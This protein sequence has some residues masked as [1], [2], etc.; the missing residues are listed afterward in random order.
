[1]SIGDMLAKLQAV[2]A[3][4]PSAACGADEWQAQARN[5]SPPTVVGD[6]VNPMEGLP[7]LALICKGC[8]SVRFHSTSFL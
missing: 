2:E 7:C 6:L 5:F 1:M 8:G 4:Q 3:T